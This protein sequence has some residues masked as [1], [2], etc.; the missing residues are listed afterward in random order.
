MVSSTNRILMT[1]SDRDGLDGG[2]LPQLLLQ[3]ARHTS[4]R[5]LAV[6]VALGL[7]VAA[8]VTILRP[9]FWISLAAFALCL[10]T[11]G[12]WGI[13]DRELADAEPSTRRARILTLARGLVGIVGAGVALLS[14]L[15]FFFGMLKTWIS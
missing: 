14:G 8:A 2:T 11:Y 10:G 4:D 6:D 13:L 12:L 15:T 9:P 3:R 1:D 5:R 7:S